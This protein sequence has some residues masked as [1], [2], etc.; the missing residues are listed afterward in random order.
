MMQH[1]L[2][3]WKGFKYFLNKIVFS[4]EMQTLKIPS[5]VEGNC[6]D[7]LGAIEEDYRGAHSISVCVCVKWFVTYRPTPFHS[8]RVYYKFCHWRELSKGFD[9]IFLH[10]HRMYLLTL[11]YKKIP[12]IFVLIEFWEIANN[13][14]FLQNLI[15]NLREI[16]EP[17]KNF[18][19]LA[20]RLFH[21]TLSSMIP[22]IL[23]Y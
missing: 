7:G 11:Y 15:L 20:I 17:L 23:I 13:P 10:R 8:L 21:T 6:T 19:K 9:E 14:C 3:E 22:G 2:K 1:F 4:G 5:I 16:S 18:R 12:T